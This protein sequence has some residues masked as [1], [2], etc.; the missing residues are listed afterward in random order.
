MRTTSR[1]LTVWNNSS[2]S[3]NHTQLAANWDLIDSYWQGIDPTTQLPYRIRTASSLPAGAAAGDLVMLT[4]NVGNF[5]AYSMA[6]YDGSQWLPV[7][8]ASVQGTLPGAPT[9]GQIVILSSA[10]S[11]F[12]AWSAV[13]WDGTK[14]DHVGIFGYV[15]TGGAANNIVGAQLAGDVFVTTSARG[16]VLT[17]RVT[18]AHYRLYISNAVVTLE[19]VS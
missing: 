3:F 8:M 16:L 17:D 15:N 11:N 14:W 7:G 12:A 18:G 9:A 10:T 1:G 4:T 19:G 5:P 6:R 2:D 13:R